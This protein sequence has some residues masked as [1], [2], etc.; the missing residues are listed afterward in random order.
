MSKSLGNVIPPE[1][2]IKQ[3]GADILRLWVVTEDYTEDIK[4]G[5]N[6]IKSIA[7]DYKKIRNTF[8]YFLGNL[9]DFNSEEDMISY[10][11]MLEIDRLILSKLQEIIEISHSSYRESKF[12]RIILMY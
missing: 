11:N 2:I 5:M 6:I 7:N 4:I 3:Y 1:K 8:R 12:H 9:Y 10:E